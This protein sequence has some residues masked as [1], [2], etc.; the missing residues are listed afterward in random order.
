MVTPQ[1][2]ERS[3][4]LSGPLRTAFR[5]TETGPSARR[6]P[7]TPP[8]FRSPA[9]FL[10]WSRRTRDVPLLG[11]GRW[12]PVVDRET[13]RR[14]P[15]RDVALETRRA[16]LQLR[17]QPGRA[18]FRHVDP[19]PGLRRAEEQIRTQQGTHG[20][21][22]HSPCT[23]HQPA[24][25]CNHR[26]AVYRGADRLRAVPCMSRIYP[27]ARH[28][29]IPSRPRLQRIPFPPRSKSFQTSFFP[30]RSGV[31]VSYV[32]RNH[33]SRTALGRHAL[34][35]YAEGHDQIVFRERRRYPVLIRVNA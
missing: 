28:H 3:P 9:P 16:T 30:L 4:S 12:M 31:F 17:H 26:W 1:R 20:T 13:S 25:N 29:A 35:G 22:M 5:G 11:Q 27:D 7:D 10:P 23:P 24:G 32:N 18:E 8:G 19:I 15:L 14:Q 33:N 21:R 6:S 2:P 34:A